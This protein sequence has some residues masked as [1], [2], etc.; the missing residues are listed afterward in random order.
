MRAVLSRCLP[1]LLLALPA[2]ADV[3]FAVLIGANAGWT[4]DRP[5]RHAE[6]DAERV[7]QALIEVGGFE[8]QRVVLLRD[9]DTAEVRAQLRRLNDRVRAAGDDALVVFYYS[10]HADARQLHLRGLPITWDEVVGAL[11][12]SPARVR[13]G[14]FDAC[15]SGSILGTKGGGPVASFEVRAEEPVQGLA[16]LTSSGADELS[17]ETR[18]LQG[19]VFTHHFVSG[20]KGA[21]DGNHDGL[22]TL[23]E[24]YQYSFERTEADTAATAVPQRP[25]FRLELKGQGDLVLARLVSASAGV[26]LPRGE[27]RRYVIT[28][29]LEWHLVAEGRSAPGADVKLMLKPGAY[30]VKRVLDDT[31]EV[32]EVSVKGG[33]TQVSQLRF[34]PQPLASGFIKGRPET[35]DPD[36]VHEYKRGEALRLLDNGE[37]YAAGVLFDELLRETPGDVG[38]QRGKARALVRQAEAFERVG[39][40]AAESAALKEALHVEPQLSEDPDFARWYRRMVELESEAGREKVIDQTVQQEISE[41]PRLKKT[42][43]VGL[44]V[45]STKGVLVLEADVA[46]LYKKVFVSLGFAPIAPGLDLSVKYVPLGWKVSPWVQAGAFYNL[47]KLWSKAPGG[48]VTANGQKLNYGDIWS[49]LIHADV[50]VQYFGSLGFHIDGGLGIMFFPKPNSSEWMWWFFPNLSLGWMF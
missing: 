49:T 2:A 17:Q 7:Q 12:D 9:P 50:G 6:S 33:L 32:A 27:A 44:D 36:E 5:L 10:G 38:A 26:V 4:N 48:T 40:H 47:S 3:R 41:N 30:K 13:L 21:A 45:F 14:L 15:R 25:A 46:L 8:A 43:G 39:D 29:A 42:F 18:T 34:S 20:L 24:L 31:L 37:A 23:N 16:L 22:V 19:S 35:Q 1:L 28:D 11:R